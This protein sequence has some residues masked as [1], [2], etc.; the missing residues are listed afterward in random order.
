MKTLASLLPL[1]AA[2]LVESF[3]LPAEAAPAAPV[4]IK[5]DVDAR[6][7]NRALLH[8][9]LEIPAAPGDMVLRYPN[10]TPGVQAPAGPRRTSGAPLRDAEGDAIPWRRDD[11]ELNP[12]LT[13][14]AGTDRVI[15]KLDYILQ[16]AV[17]DS[18]RGRR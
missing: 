5:M 13:V 10:G 8:A 14:P 2:M 9:R 3:S 1:L 17:G 15:V 4:Q 7:L 11:E 16:S 6:E 12:L 18:R